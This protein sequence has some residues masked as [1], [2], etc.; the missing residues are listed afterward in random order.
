MPD[1]IE[2]VNGSVPVETENE[3]IGSGRVES[4][5]EGVG[6]RLSEN[7]ENE[8]SVVAD[9][10]E[11]GEK[12]DYESA[13]LDEV[14]QNVEERLTLPDTDKKARTKKEHGKKWI[15]AIL[16]I[17]FN[18]VALAVVLYL[19]LNNDSEGF[20]HVGELFKVLGAHREW[21]VL[22]VLAFLAHLAVDSLIYFVLI[23]Q[24]GY[25][26]RY[27]LSL[28]TSILG[29]YYNNITPWSSGGQPF[30]MAYLAKC[31]IDTMARKHFLGRACGSVPCDSRNFAYPAYDA[32]V[33]QKTGLDLQNNRKGSGARRET[34]TC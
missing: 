15:A 18:A 32:G 28:R 22:I 9:R 23:K 24:C 31:N 21:L 34:E 16:L 17:A 29:F 5:T 10:A 11:S 27:G 6:E 33:F 2:N 25:G 20:L 19:E 1:K 8:S 30:Q 4:G 14:M 13:S 7:A 26:N 3:G 12:I